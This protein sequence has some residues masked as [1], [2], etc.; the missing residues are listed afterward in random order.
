MMERATDREKTAFPWPTALV[1]AGVVGVSAAGAA[2]LLPAWGARVGFDSPLASALLALL[3]LG[4]ML[5]FAFALE[6]GKPAP[7][8]RHAL[9]PWVLFACLQLGV[10][11]SGGPVSPLVPA[12]ALFFIILGRHAAWGASLS[13]LLLLLGLQG[14]PLAQA[15]RDGASWWPQALGLILPPLGLA[16][17]SLSRNATDPPLRR[18]AAEAPSLTPVGLSPSLPLDPDRQAPLGA[19]QLQREIETALKVVHH[20]VE[21]LDALTLWWGDASAVQL[22]QGLVRSG[23]L[24]LGAQL[25]PGESLLGLALREQR[26]LKVEPIA[27]AAAAD[28]PYRQQASAVQCLCVLPLKDE[29]RLVGLLACDK[30]DTAFSAEE[31]A[32]LEALARQ[33]VAL[34]Q[35]AAY[36][37]RLQVQ[38]GRTQRLYAAAQALGQD[39]DREALLKR[40]AELLPT[41]V[42]CDSW[43]LGMREEDD[44]APLMRLAGEGYAASAPAQLSLDRSAA[45]AASLAQAE[46]A[47]LFNRSAGAQVPAALQEGLLSEAQ[48][49]LLAPLRLGGR[50][51]GVLKL[52]RRQQPFTEEER[53][54]AFIFASQAAVTLEHA[55]LY[56]L[57]RR[58]ATTDGLTGLYNHRFFQERLAL[59]LEKAALSGQSLCLAL[60]DIDFFKKFN[61][62]FGHQEG[63][64]VLRKVAQLCQ[65]RARPQDIVC[66][67]GGEEFVVI[68]P[69]CDIVE[70][71]AVMDGLRAYC[72]E[73]MIGGSGPEAR[74]INLSIGLCAYPQGAKEQRELIHVADAALY[75]AKHFGRNQVRS[76]KDL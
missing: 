61:D 65:Q 40:F 36:Q 1:A 20:A 66:R 51:S 59:E 75:K 55:R 5:F 49:F 4:P 39:L 32:A 73:H 24:R 45:L 23:A 35:R 16:I 30:A 6:R 10:Q 64:V 71:R 69:D 54:I 26:R 38:A 50:L 29:G 48:H 60:T 70:A 3:S 52:D 74:A 25:Q 22:S 53:E 9:A 27:A 7:A 31:E 57:H 41:L 62:V 28:L 2:G 14:L 19:E 76:Y 63:D 18:R 11:L 56:T 17:G 13:L 34:A 8:L 67:Y 33:L 68:M 47:L 21:S 37:E 44:D 43:T 42:P 12:Y 58:L 15:A 72:A 46:G